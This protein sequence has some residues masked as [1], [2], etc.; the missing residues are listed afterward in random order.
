MCRL[1]PPHADSRR[2]GEI[3][4]LS[5]SLHRDSR[6]HSKIEGLSFQMA[7]VTRNMVIF[8]PF[9]VGQKYRSIMRVL[10]DGLTRMVRLRKSQRGDIVGYL[11][12]FAANSNWNTER[13]RHL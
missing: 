5:P 1:R 13:G 7:K 2:T 4:T 6:Q 10:P 8:L 3:T 11:R 12:H 9:G